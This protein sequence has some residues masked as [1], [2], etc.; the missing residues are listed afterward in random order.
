MDSNGCDKSGSGNNAVG[1]GFHRCYRGI[2][3]ACAR[4]PGG[5]GRSLGGSR[6]VGSVARTLPSSSR[7]PD[8][9]CAGRVPFAAH[10][11][12]CAAEQTKTQLKYLMALSPRSCRCKEWRRAM[13]YQLHG[14]RGRR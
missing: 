6:A 5:C 12:A 11:M 2:F 7:S 3:A 1:V 9:V 4:D 8:C 13:E 10:W 14:R